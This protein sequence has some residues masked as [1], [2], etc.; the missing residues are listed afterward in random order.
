MKPMRPNRVVHL[1]VEVSERDRDE[2]DDPNIIACTVLQRIFLL[3]SF[4]PEALDQAIQDFAA[5]MSRL[6]TAQLRKEG[7]L[8]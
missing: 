6:A 5:E 1:R 3:D 4:E 7:F 2:N 8:K